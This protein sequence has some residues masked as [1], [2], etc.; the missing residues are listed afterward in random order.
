V[1]GMREIPAVAAT[2]AATMRSPGARRPSMM[3]LRMSR[4]A[5]L[6]SLFR[7]EGGGAAAFQDGAREGAVGKLLE[8][9]PA[10]RRGDEA[11]GGPRRETHR[12]G[13][14]ARR[15]ARPP[16]GG[17]PRPRAGPA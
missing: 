9:L 4:E 12:T 1:T 13:E 6:S 14:A 11:R 10:G 5:S 3:A 17:P 7:G 2:L 16:F 8:H 15:G